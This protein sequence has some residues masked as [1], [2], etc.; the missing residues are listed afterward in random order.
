MEIAGESKQVVPHAHIWRTRLIR[1]AIALLWLIASLWALA[2]FLDAHT[3][4][5]RWDFSHYYL[6]AL[7]MRQGANPYRIRL[8]SMPE[9]KGM[10]LKQ[11]DHASYPPSFLLCFEPLTL[12]S[13]VRAYWTWFGIN[14]GALALAL[15]MLLGGKREIGFYSAGTL[16]ALAILYSPLSYHIRFAQ[17]QIVILLCLVLMMRALARGNDPLAGLTLAFA[18]LIKVFPLA[19]AGYL[20]VERR[21]GALRWMAAGLAIGGCLTLGLVGV[22]RSFSFFGQARFLTDQYWYDLETNVSLSAN[23]S[24]VFWYLC[25]DSLG[26][27]LNLLRHGIIATLEVWVLWLT[28]KATAIRAQLGRDLDSRGFALWVVAM[29]TLAPTAWFHYLVLLYIPFA[30]IAIASLDMRT[31]RR[32]RIMAIASYVC[33]VLGTLALGVLGQASA[34]QFASILR[35]SLIVPLVMAYIATYWLVCD[36]PG[37]APEIISATSQHAIAHS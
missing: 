31:S 27:G 9:A 3:R 21:W 8:D 28:V 29:I 32:V 15:G 36:P 5:K 6:S 7:A 18:G 11:I 24:K 17:T 16:V 12:M 33:T 2:M 37:K 34:V 22:G 14:I 30:Q 10:E 23:I 1:S 26:W 35:D 20:I 25:G 13:P 19:M 4:V